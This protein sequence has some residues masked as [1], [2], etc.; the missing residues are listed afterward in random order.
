MAMAAAT[1]ATAGALPAMAAT[2]R[3]RAG[4]AGTDV[5]VRTESAVTVSGRDAFSDLKVTVGQTKN[6]VHQAV[7]VSWTGGVPTNHEQANPDPVKFLTH[8]LQIF[9]CWGDD[10]GT[11]HD[12]PGPPPEQCEFGAEPLSG[13]N[14]PVAQASSNYRRVIATTDDNGGLTV[15]RSQ[16]FFQPASGRDTRIGELWKPFRAVDGTMVNVQVKSIPAIQN[17]SSSVTKEWQNSFFDFITTNELRYGRTYASGAGSELFEAETGEESTGLGCGQKAQPRADASRAIPRCW[18]VIVPRGGAE[19]NLPDPTDYVAKSPLAPS[20]WAN[21][22]AVPLE[23]N[24]RDSPCAIGADE[25][26]VAGSELSTAAVTNWQPALCATPGSP[27]YAYAAESDDL[28]RRQVLTGGTGSPGMGVVSQPIDPAS[29]DASNP[30]TYAPFTLSGVVIG[31]NIERRAN[32][33]SNDAVDAQKPIAGTR[34][35]RINLTPRLVAKLLTESYRSEFKGPAIETPEYAWLKDNPSTLADDPEFL[36]YNPEFQDLAMGTAVTGGS[37]VVEASTSDAASLVWQWVLADSEARA[38]LSGTP[39]PG[40]MN[41]NPRY[42]T[43]TAR[44]PSGGAFA[45]PNPPN[46]FPKSDPFCFEDPAL[47]PETPPRH[48]RPLC[49]LDIHPYADSMEVAAQK[50]RSA[51]QGAKTLHDPDNPSQQTAPTWYG[52]DGPETQGSRSILSVTD[53]ASAARFGLQVAGL[54]PARAGDDATPRTFVVPDQPALLAGAQAMVPGPVPGVLRPDPAKAT[55]GAYPLAL[56]TYAAVAPAHLPVDARN[57]YAALVDFAA[58]R[59]QKPGFSFGDL[60]PGY[61]PLPANLRAQATTAAKA[62]RDGVPPTAAAPPDAAP[63]P[64]PAAPP[65]TPSAGTGGNGGRAPSDA[66]PGSPPGDTVPTSPPAPAPT[67]DG[68][69]PAA[70]TRALTRTA[71]AAVGVIRYTLPLAILVA[72]IA[73]LGAWLLTTRR[74]S[75]AVTAGRTSP[76]DS[77]EPV[78]M[79]H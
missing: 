62:I 5:P 8:F 56:L 37:L 34:A 13:G 54:S 53:T 57:D 11:N 68:S 16:G 1:A 75:S 28:A 59:G 27:P 17:G 45:Q 6:L 49:M 35:G 19:E 74:R 29:V 22:I 64:S 4:T 43:V 23:F 46:T 55:A 61:A 63:Q 18:M 48:P 21:R 79:A 51:N 47:T 41:V 77:D 71:A 66:T 52:A 44:N 2:P 78:R 72:L 69:P 15:D 50:T 40:G 36:Q 14:L 30:I 33:N 25:R 67:P 39:A 31:F 58:G 65:G 70:L 32:V 38:W 73:G 20:V 7:S 24:P 3:D 12:N 10:D 76:A 60:P 42:N 26:R 9:Q